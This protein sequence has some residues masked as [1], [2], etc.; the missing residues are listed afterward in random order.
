MSDY[1]QILGVSKTA[2]ADEIKKAFRKKAMQNHPD[3]HKGDASAEKKFKEI[4]EAYDVLKDSQK[5]SQYDQF[6]K[7]GMNG[8]QSGGGFGGQGGF[9]NFDFGGNAGGFSDIFENIFSEFAGQQRGGGR[10]RKARGADLVFPVQITLEEAFAGLKKSI[11]YK[12]KSSC[13]TCKGTGSKD[14]KSPTTCT[15]CNGSGIVRTR[16]GFF[17]QE[18]TCPSCHGSGKKIENPCSS[19]GGFG[20]K[21]NV[22]ELNI[23]IPKGIETGMRIRISGEGNSAPFGGA[24]GD[25][26]IETH[27]EPHVNFEREGPDLFTNVRISFTTAILGGEFELKMLDGKAGNIKIPKGTQP[28]SQIRLRKKGMPVVN[29]SLHGD[30]YLNIEVVIPKKVNDAQIKALETFEKADKKKTFGIF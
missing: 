26:F 8:G 10:A 21:E 15:E 2:S 16:Q 4:N 28:N 20:I 29:S 13:E 7:A 11:R 24:T 19:C 5:R 30:L 17:V 3:K 27:I 6:G 1:Y 22:R 18:H 12:R 14:K 25:L 9:G 23:T